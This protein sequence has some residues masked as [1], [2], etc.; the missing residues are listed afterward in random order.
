MIHGIALGLLGLSGLLLP[1]LAAIGQETERETADCWAGTISA[2]RASLRLWLEVTKDSSGGMTATFDN[3]DLG[4]TGAGCVD[5]R[6]DGDR[7]SFTVPSMGASYTGRLSAD[8]TRIVGTWNQGRPRPLEFIRQPKGTRPAPRPMP[9]PLPARP[10]VPIDG[11]K[12]VLDEAFAPVL[13]HGV[14]SPA[15]GGGITIGVLAGGRREVFAY[16]ATRP[17]SIFEIGSVTK[18]FTALVLA[19]MVERK[20]VTLDQPV[21]ELLPPGAVAKPDGPE[22]TLLDLATQ[23]SGLPRLPANLHAESDPSNPYAGYHEEHLLAL[24]AKLGVAR[25]EKQEFHYSNLGY[26][27]LGFVLARLEGLSYEELVHRQVTGPLRLVDTSVHLSWSQRKRVIE[28]HNC[29]DQP[30][31]LWTFDVMAGG[32]A[33]RSSAADMLRYLDAQLHPNS[34]TGFDGKYPAASTLP[35]AIPMTH[36]LRGDG[37]PE[38]KTGMGWLYSEQKQ[39]YV[40]DGGTGGCTAFA[41]FQPQGDRAIVVLH[42]RQDL[43]VGPMS[44]TCRVAAHVMSLL[45]GQPTIPL[46]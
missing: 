9:E 20:K 1:A 10:P 36:I 4:A 7:F 21:R 24:L 25:P 44:F 35:A 12:G 5:V 18:T 28:A 22:I 43:G 34:A 45:S 33:L 32:S 37:P 8:G 38:M 19:Q 30:V 6:L 2:G 11:L 13:E 41:A 42:N 3:L 39:A 16:G 27:L 14:L 40:Q 23:R 15:T 17:Q 31:P 29:I 46:E 26:G